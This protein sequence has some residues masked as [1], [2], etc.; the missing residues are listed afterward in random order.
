MKYYEDYEDPLKA[1][2]PL[3]YLALATLALGV[4]SSIHF[5]LA[6]KIRMP[7]HP[8]SLVMRRVQIDEVLTVR[9]TAPPRNQ[10]NSARRHNSAPRHVRLMRSSEFDGVIFSAPLSDSTASIVGPTTLDLHM[11]RDPMEA[12]GSGAIDI[13]G[14]R[15]GSEVLLDP[16]RTYEGA[17]AEK[18]RRERLGYGAMILALLPGALL[19]LRAR[20]LWRESW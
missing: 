2:R 9:V 3:G 1:L 10:R 11:D 7:P 16:V 14:V 20:R 5:S 17:L 15:R 19:F 13:H 6:R 12:H 18:R 8:D 4:I